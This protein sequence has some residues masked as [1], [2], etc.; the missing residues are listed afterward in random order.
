[1]HR[2]D[3]D[4]FINGNEDQG[5]EAT[6]L[7][8]EWFNS[9]Q[10]ELSNVVEGFGDALDGSNDSQLF[11]ALKGRVWDNFVGHGNLDLSKCSGNAVVICDLVGDDP[12]VSVSGFKGIL[13]IARHKN[14][15]AFRFSSNGWECEVPE[16]GAVIFSGVNSSYTVVTSADAAVFK[17]ILKAHDIRA[18]SVVLEGGLDAAGRI[19]GR[20]ISGSE[21]AFSKLVSPDEEPVG[22]DAPTVFNKLASF[23]KGVTISAEGAFVSFAKAT[24][25]NVVNF[26]HSVSFSGKTTFVGDVDIKGQSKFSG[27]CSMETVDVSNLNGSGRFAYL[28]LP[29]SVPSDP[30]E[31]SMYVSVQGGSGSSGV[32]YI[33]VLNV[34][35]GDSWHRLLLE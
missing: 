13:G 28:K 34:F 18:N 32:K 7:N 14:G 9:V 11:D 15:S 3:G 8:A 25:N 2:I 16:F 12:A 20:S 5:I 6:K 35:A 29:T 22:I 27:F 19:A 4:K 23:I 26:M 1:M 21:G 17:N 10:E 31:G 30:E 33:V 24:F